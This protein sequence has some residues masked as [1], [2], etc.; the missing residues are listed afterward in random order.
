MKVYSTL[1]TLLNMLLKEIYLQNLIHVSGTTEK[2]KQR[3]M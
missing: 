1:Q 2:A 3:E